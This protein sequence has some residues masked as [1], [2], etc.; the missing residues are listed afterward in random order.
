[1]LHIFLVILKIIGIFLLAAVGL[2]LILILA[3]LFVPIKYRI[4]LIAETV[5]TINIKS[6]ILCTYSGA[7]LRLRIVYDETLKWNLRLFGFRIKSGNQKSDKD[8]KKNYKRRRT[9]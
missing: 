2:L 4:K 6:D 9:T 8:I 5:D 7:L 1:M 3:V